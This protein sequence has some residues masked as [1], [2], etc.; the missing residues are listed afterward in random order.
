MP[1]AIE[2]DR[3]GGPEVLEYREI[4]HTMPDRGQVLI[5]VR[6][7]G[8]NPIEW[9]IR[10]G[11][12]SSGPFTG[13]RR[14]G[15]D[16]AGVIVAVGEGLDGWA[17]GDEVIVSN[18]SG[19]YATELVSAA[20]KLTRK[21]SGLSWE[22]AA[23]IPIPVGTAHQAI[24]SLGVGEADTFL[25]HGGSGAVG[26]AAIQLARRL[27][28]TVVATAS[29]ANH[30]RLRQLGAIPI[31]YG[32]GLADR[33]RAAAPQGVDVALDGAGTDEAIE[34]SKELVA[35]HRRVAT[36][37]QGARAAEL[38]IRAWGGGNPVPLT[39]EEAALRVD[40]V[41]LAA[42]LAADGVFELEIA[43]RYPLTEAA[44]AHRQSETGHVRGKIVLIP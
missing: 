22:E 40:A 7:I 14:L 20:S 3:L 31:A 35:D 13:P 23:A 2:Y 25:L 29:E 43:R 30:E 1:Y 5:E 11:V 6:A 36:I 34:V 39:A 19:A 44:E 8:V 42:Q 32:P 16:A 4:A 17:I 18:A 24:T 41:P 38:G 12:R 37:V 28:A 27:G 26:Q 10:S 33:V 15:A 21:P 9:K